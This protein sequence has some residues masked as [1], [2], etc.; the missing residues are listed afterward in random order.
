MKPAQAA[1]TSKAK[2]RVMPSAACTRIAVAGNAWSGVVV[3]RMITSTSA[4]FM[5]GMGQRALARP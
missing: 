3:A 2:P 1:A 4:A 5:P